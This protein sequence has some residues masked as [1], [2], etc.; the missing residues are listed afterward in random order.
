MTTLS[1]PTLSKQPSGFMIQLKANTM[2]FE[3]PLNGSVQTVDLPGARWICE[4]RYD[5]LIKAD[6]LILQAFL[7]QLRGRAGRAYLWDMSHPIPQGPATGS[8]LVNG[9]S[10]T[11]TTLITDGWTSGITGILKPGDL[12]GCNGQVHRIVSTITSD[13]SGNATLTFEPP[14]RSAPA[15]NEVI[16]VT[17]PKFTAM[18]M[19]DDQDIYSARTNL[20]TI[21]DSGMSL[22]FCEA[23]S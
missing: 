18:L 12:F 4:V 10:Q 11:G 14:M 23:F 16:T 8:P 17:E 22:K 1:F 20:Y 3:S 13:G 21:P 2:A 19:D 7:A 5:N 9:S 15:D 6:R